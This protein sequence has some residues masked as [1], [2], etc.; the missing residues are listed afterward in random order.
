MAI[1][2]GFSGL[3]LIRAA[4]TIKSAEAES[5]GI[6]G[7]ASSVTGTAAA[8]ASGQAHVKFGN[9]YKRF[10]NTVASSQLAA[11]TTLR[12]A[13]EALQIWDDQYHVT[14]YVTTFPSTIRPPSFVLPVAAD[15]E[16]VKQLGLALIDEW[17]KYP[18][19]FVAQTGLQSISLGKENYIDGTYRASVYDNPDKLMVYDVGY[20]ADDYMRGVIH[21]E[22]WHYIEANDGTLGQPLTEWT[23]LN[24]PG[25]QYGNG[26]PSCYEPD[27][28][29]LSGDHP[30][31]GFVSGYGASS[32]AE[33]RAEY[34]AYLMVAE[35]YHKVLAWIQTDQTLANKYAAFKQLMSDHSAQMGGSYLDDINGHVVAVAQAAEA[36]VVRQPVD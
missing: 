16:H 22:Y 32:V 33:D 21:H 10:G 7:N 3:L 35:R 14:V 20:G 36:R 2:G 9:A 6:A 18:V 26:G 27:N 24:V 17:S 25:F 30:I 28:D 23:D 15:L 1:V 8:G 4:T 5:G 13:E 11:A 29:C 19:D 12:Q 31:P 34:F